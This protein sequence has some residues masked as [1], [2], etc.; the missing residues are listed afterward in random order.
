M[1]VR[2]LRFERGG[3][4][5][6]IGLSERWI[7]SQPLQIPGKRDEYRASYHP[8]D[9]D[10]YEMDLMTDGEPTPQ[11]RVKNLDRFELACAISGMV[12]VTEP[13]TP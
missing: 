11:Y 6:R 4:E 5:G 10:V 12:E 3:T 1:R 13:V 9:P 7:W 2:D 8:T